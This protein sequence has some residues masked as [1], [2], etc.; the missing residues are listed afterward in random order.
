M[1]NYFGDVPARALQILQDFLFTRVLVFSTLI[2]L[3]GVA[4]A[5]IVA[6][7]LHQPFRDW[8]AMIGAQTAS[9]LVRRAIAIATPLTL[10][11][12]WLVLQTL[13][14]AAAQAA[15]WPSDVIRIVSTLLVAWL[16]IRFA[17]SFIR[18]RL[19]AK[20][21]AVT[22]WTI[23]ALSILNLLDATLTFLDGLA[24][25]LGT[26]RLSVL[27]LIKGLFTLGF[28]LWLAAA[29]ARY[30]ENRLRVLA[31]LTLSVQVL[32]GNLARIALLTI[33]LLVGL[34]SVGIDISALALIGGA[35][36]VGVG[37]GLQ[38]IVSNFVSGVIILLE[39]SIKPG[40]VI[41]VGST[42]GW[43]QTMSPR[44]VAVLARDGTRHN[45][46]NDELI[47][48]TVVNWSLGYDTVLLKVPIGISYA[49]DPRDA[50]RLAIEAAR[51]TPRVLPDPAPICQVARFG[52]SSV[53]LE[54]RFWLRDP[55]SGTENARSEVLLRIW[56]KFRVHRIDIAYPQRDL[57][58]RPD[59]EITVHLSD[60]EAKS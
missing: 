6:F 35:I 50:I 7:A 31:E 34:A 43:V 16:I 2:Q 11:I 51:E 21:V 53:D 40:D 39:R 14:Q 8:L 10:P 57:H 52:E 19:W 38:K 37:L 54:L 27:A 15:D 13:A 48:R 28:L 32:V 3:V 46:P 18:E 12:V 56:D 9:A 1:E 25:T 20:L 26:L 22:A 41:E 33:A 45:I 4:A 55:R 29:T 59:S 36:G 23:A 49:S 44:Y 47:A 60:R 24:I 30:L 58:V 17:A 5:L 42:F